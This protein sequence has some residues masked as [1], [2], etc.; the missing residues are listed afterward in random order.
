MLGYSP[1]HPDAVSCYDDALAELETGRRL[2]TLGA[3][4]T[5]LH[6]LPIG[7]GE[8]AVRADVEHLV[9]GPA[10][11]FCLTSTQSVTEA[12]LEESALDAR[13]VSKHL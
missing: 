7:D 2:A 1:L 11:V 3:G 10:G 6:S 8:G 13:Q 4:Y 12:R 9:I 5:V